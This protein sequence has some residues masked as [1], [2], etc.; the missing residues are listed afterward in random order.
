MKAGYLGVILLLVVWWQT[1]KERKEI[2]SPLN[3]EIRQ[4][5]RTISL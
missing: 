4:L 5:H 2:K 3:P 1:Q